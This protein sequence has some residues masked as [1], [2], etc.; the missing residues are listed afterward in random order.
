[1][2]QTCR[3][4]S[5]I[6]PDD[7]LYCYHDGAQLSS[8]VSMLGPAGSNLPAFPVAFV[9]RS[10][11]VCSNFDQFVRACQE[12]WDGAVQALREGRMA[13]FFDQIF[14]PDLAFN[15][16]SAGRAPD[17]SRGLH[18]LLGTIPSTAVAAPRLNLSPL[19][20]DLG[21]VQVGQDSSFELRLS[22]AGGRLLFGNVQ[23]DCPWLSLGSPGVVPVKDFQFQSEQK[24]QVRVCGKLLRACPRPLEGRL[25]VASN[26]GEATVEVRVQV[27]AKPFPSGVLAGAASPRQLVDR[28]MAAPYE[29]SPWLDNGAVRDWYDANGWN[30]PVQ[31]PAAVG[32]DAVVQ[33]F[34]ALGIE[35]TPP[36]VVHLRGAVGEAL[37][38]VL[39][40]KAR[41]RGVR[42]V[43]AQ[44]T[45]D[46]TWLGIGPTSIN[47]SA[48][49]VLLVVPAVPN[50]PGQTL[51]ARVSLTLNGKYQRVI[52]VT[53]S[54]TDGGPGYG[55]TRS[56]R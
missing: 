5:S 12:D 15:A 22:N 55:Q 28:M 50:M 48:A 52:P 8:R 1:M 42:P 29:A 21:S 26:G 51:H 6:N 53:L 40:I 11:K 30:Y 54:V 10:G 18:E 44:A 13:A 2:V 46:Q 49:T 35:W 47:D 19:E 3:R 33:F 37:G 24:I 7:A 32:L 36:K 45:S 41:A 23:T 31:G 20:V 25:G 4:C 27:V 17:P 14:R 38:H 16:Q 39:E 9:F 43:S 34:R 56:R